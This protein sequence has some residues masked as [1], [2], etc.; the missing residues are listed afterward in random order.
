MREALERE[1]APVLIDQEGGRVQRIGPPHLRAYPAGAVYGRALRDGPAGSAWRRRFSARELIAL[2]LVRSRHQR[3]LRARA[4]HAGRGRDDGDRR[5]RARRQR[6]HRSRRSAARSSTALMRGGLLPVIK[7]MPGHGRA[8][9][10][11]HNDLPRSTPR[12]PSWRRR[13][14]RLSG[15]SR[16][17]RPLGMT[18]HVVFLDVDDGAPAT[19]SAVSDW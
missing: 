12:W 2:D 10:D 18:A 9:V 1:D 7:H 5:P 3:Q 19:L 6:R 8:L 17:A 15:C 14:S 13:I 16:Q 4:R 11:S